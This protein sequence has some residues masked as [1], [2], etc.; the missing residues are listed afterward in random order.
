M[1]MCSRLIRLFRSLKKKHCLDLEAWKMCT[2]FV[3]GKDV[4]KGFIFT[5]LLVVYLLVGTPSIGIAAGVRHALEF[6][7]QDDYIATN[8]QYLFIYETGEFSASAWIHVYE[9]AIDTDTWNSVL[10][11]GHAGPFRVAVIQDGVIRCTYDGASRVDLYSDP[12]PTNQW[13][14]VLVQGDGSTLQLY[15]DGVLADDAAIVPQ[16]SAKTPNFAIGTWPDRLG[17]RVMNGIIDDVRIWNRPL[18]QEEI[19]EALDH[20][21]A[22]D[23]EGLVGYWTFNEG[24]GNI[25]YDISPTQNHGTITGAIWTMNTAPMALPTIAFAP[26]PSN[27]AVDVPRDVVLSWSPGS[28]AITHDVYLGTVF[29]DVSEATR[30]NPL[31]VLVSEGQAATTY[32]PQNVLQFGQTY[33][34]RIDELDN[35][36]TYKGEVWNFTVEP[37]GYPL[38]SQRI[39]ATASSA[40]STDEQAEK[41]IDGSGLDPNDMHSV[42]PT[43]MWLSD[44][45][46]LDKAWIEYAFDK[47]EGF[48]LEFDGQD[49]YVVTNEQYP[50]INESGGFTTSAWVHVYQH[51]ISTDTWNSV[52]G[53]GHAGPY[54]VAVI[55]DGKVRCTWDGESRVNLYSDPIPENQW[56]H[57][58]VQGDGSTLQLFIDGNPVDEVAII[59]TAKESVNFAIGTWP[60]NL[61]Q[62]VMNGIIDDVR[63]WNKPLSEGE[64]QESLIQ[65]LSGDEEGLVGYWTFNEGEGD[66]AFDRSPSQ[67][68]GTISGASWT[69]N[70]VS[71]A[72]SGNAEDSNTGGPPP[73][74]LDQ[75]LVWN[76]NTS[77]EKLVGFG[78]KEAIIQYSLDGKEWTTLGETHEFAQASGKDDYSPI[79][80]IDFGGVLAKYVRITANSN[81][82]GALNQYG[83]SE[84]RFL[85]IPMTAR[86][87]YPAPGATDVAPKTQLSWR[88]GR[89]AVTHEVYLSTDEQKVL[90]GT[91]LVGT[92]SEPRFDATNL[93]KLGQTHYWKINEV[94]DLADPAVWEGDVWSFTVPESIVVDNFENYSDDDAAGKAIWQ[95]WTDGFGIA[96]NGSQVGN[97]EPPY[98]ERMIVHGGKNSM[99]LFYSNT[100]GATMSEAT[101]NFDVPQDW[102]LHGIQTLVLYFHGAIAN[103][104]QLYVKI[105]NAKLTYD[106]NASDLAIPKW[107]QWNL[108][109]ASVNSNLGNVTML[110]IGVEGAGASGVL[111]VDDIYLYATAPMIP[112]TLWIEAEA[113]TVTDPMKIQNVA[114]GASGDQYVTMPPLT[115][116]TDNPPTNGRV[117]IPF[118]VESGT[119]QI[120]TRVVAPTDGD[121][122]MWLRIEGATTNT[123]NHSSGWVQ[124]DLREGKDWHW[125]DIYSIDDGGAVVNFTL[126]AGQHNLEFAYREDGLLIDAFLII[127]VD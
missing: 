19:L 33:Y 8:E 35:S 58:L 121:D 86:E 102:T 16:I 112:E 30:A 92:V 20:E 55:Q 81:W 53:R 13:R 50:F 113:G 69:G 23:E 90:D 120:Q 108:D 124:A 107:T 126:E 5:V 110:T 123:T 34:W 38:P 106:D 25:A 98:A 73:V 61:G 9:H 74:K 77:V 109:L 67:N 111:Y 15:V 46:D 105:N 75:M 57:I 60:Q 118:D 40:N 32:A 115:N 41:T 70:A 64:I 54:R 26:D 24:Q 68:H 91:A 82:G 87:P 10:G 48:A 17:Q 89:Q 88:A 101:L 47:A 93:T 22:G 37:T 114:G 71:L 96:N 122:S 79:T 100:N 66:I 97:L 59:P 65:A 12:I 18:L 36:E 2:F 84:V 29:E 21:L 4:F 125:S 45:A 6:D 62:R 11:T 117:T 85:S 7:G 76:H 42:E 28:L 103:T 49:D 94:N 39:T 83:L 78:V 1:I 27:S 51:A 119:Y 44:A 95:A 14:H 31:D 80:A 52:V 72:S 99:P 116:S 56:T 104:G 3:K 43:D 127:K 63:V